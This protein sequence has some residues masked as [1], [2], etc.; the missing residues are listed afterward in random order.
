M[1]TPEKNKGYTCKLK[2]EKLMVMY[3]KD[4][5]KYCSSIFLMAK[6]QT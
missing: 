3:K 4:A 5:L 6:Q 2:Y 1:E